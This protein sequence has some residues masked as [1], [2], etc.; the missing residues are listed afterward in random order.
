MKKQVKIAIGA[1]IVL[2]FAGLVAT[3]MMKPQEE[4][5]TKG[6]PAVTLTTATEGSI[7]QTTAHMEGGGQ[8]FRTG[9]FAAGRDGAGCGESYDTALRVRRYLGAEL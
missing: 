8:C 3:R 6:L 9:G 1:V 4:M 2:G 5:Q 7:E